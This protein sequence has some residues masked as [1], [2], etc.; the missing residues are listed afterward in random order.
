MKL[1]SQ[2]PVFQQYGERMAQAFATQSAEAP[3]LPTST[4][5]P[6]P[7][8][9][10]AQ[11]GARMHYAAPLALH[12]EGLLAHLYT[13]AY[14]GPGTG[15]GLA[16]GVL[17]SLLSLPLLDRA[18]G[19][20]ADL[21]SSKVS[22]FNLFGIR[23]RL[24][25]R[26]AAKSADLLQAYLKNGRLFSKKVVARG[27]HGADVI[28]AYSTAAVELF[29]HA[30]SRKCRCILEQMMAPKL[31][32]Y[33]MVNAEYERFPAW[34][35]K[36][37]W[38][39]SGVLDTHSVQLEEWRL[40]DGIIAPSGW[41]SSALRNLGVPAEKIAVVPYGLPDGLFRDRFIRSY[42]GDRPLRVLMVAG[43]LHLQKGLQYLLEAAENLCRASSRCIQ[44]RCVGQNLLRPSIAQRFNGVVQFAGP[45]SRTKVYQHYKWGDIFVFPSLCESM[46]T[47][48]HEALA[49]GMPVITTPNSG[50]QVRD[51]VDGLIVPP[52]DAQA[53]ADAIQRYLDHPDLVEK[54]SRSAMAGSARFGLEVY[55]RRLVHALKQFVKGPS[56]G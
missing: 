14:A 46:S 51:G 2:A 21:P 39:E 33:E 38:T 40:A 54:M 15:A 6:G 17:S 50:S 19:L 4:D 26:H 43:S 9:V 34:E 36:P 24:R 16:V 41:V 10:V 23:A 44:V 28:Y 25:T 22:S 20:S 56:V 5:D 48:V 7:R 13:D 29:R 30:R 45:I 42:P 31:A 27:L 1:C 55:R 12:A 47:A 18:G 32:E 53:L 52:R 37:R 3:T 35:P 8:V 49:N 11:M